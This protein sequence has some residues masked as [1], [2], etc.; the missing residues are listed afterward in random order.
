MR[1]GR[2]Y[3]KERRERQVKKRETYESIEKSNTV[4]NNVII[5]F[6]EGG[7]G[8]KKCEEIMIG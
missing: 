7:L 6:S 2:G 3:T 4:I 1:G 8:K 5:K